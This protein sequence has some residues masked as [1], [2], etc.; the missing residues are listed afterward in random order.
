MFVARLYAYAFLGEF[1]LI[2]PVYTLLFADAGLSVA[3]TSSLFVIWSVTGLVLEVPSGAWADAVSRRLLLFLGPL[4]AGAGYAL[5]VLIP[6]YWAFAAGFVL[7]G[8]Q[9]ALVSGAYEALAYEELARRGRESRYAAVMGRAE[10][11]GLVANA[12]AIGLAVPVFAAG[13]YPVVGAAS[14]LACV[15]GAVTALTLPERRGAREAGEGGYLAVLRAGIAEARSDPG[16]LRALL[17]VAFVT[18]IWGALEEYVPFL[19]VETGVA[20][21]AVPVLVLV[22]WVGATA[23]GLLAG[24]A[25]R[26]PGRGY[27]LTVAAAAVALAA[28]ALS[29]H[30]AGFVLIAVAFGAFQLAGVVA[31]ARLQERITGPARATVTSVAGLGVNVVTLGV[32]AAYGAMSG[33]VSNGVA[34]ALLAAPYAV[35]AV[36]AARPERVTAQ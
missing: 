24:A 1:I 18:A 26:M 17:L 27:A 21:T 35:I 22:V 12:L 20:R 15:L 19:G 7:W 3:E 8:A 36:L 10:A 23:G 14:V 11:A 5:W 31:D 4:L 25:R 33:V 28:G 29:G 32:Y 16:V 2:Y 9:G 34:F 6:S 30:P 13:G